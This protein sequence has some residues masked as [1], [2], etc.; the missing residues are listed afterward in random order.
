MTPDSGRSVCVQAYVSMPEEPVSQVNIT[1]SIQESVC[2]KITTLCGCVR[3]CAT[4]L[5]HA[6]L[7]PG[8]WSM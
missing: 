4:Q 7:Q 3:V 5:G 6:G 1:R 8:Q 2:M